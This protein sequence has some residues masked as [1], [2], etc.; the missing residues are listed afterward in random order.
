MISPTKTGASALQELGLS[1]KDF[2]DN[3]GNMKSMTDIFGLLHDKMQGMG[4]N[5]QTDIF[6]NL[7]GITGQQA[8]LI[9][10]DNAKQLGELNQK[11]ADSAKNDYVGKLAKKNSETGKVAL[12]IVKQSVNAISMTLL[13]APQSAISQIGDKLAK[14]AGTKEFG[15]AVK[16]VGKWVGNLTDKVADFF[17][18]LG[19]HSN[20]LKGITHLCGKKVKDIDPG[21]WDTFFGIIMGIGKAFGQVFTNGKKAEELQKNLNEYLSGIAMHVKALKTI[22]GL[23]AGIW[24]ADKVANFA[25]KINDVADA[26]GGLSKKLKNSGIQNAASEKVE[27]TGENISKGTLTKAENR[28]I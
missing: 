27:K 17:T 12:D 8:G 14:A 3:K 16:G 13:R 4:K 9:L 2:T 6:H 22:G 21:A 15:N 26:F 7:F 23:L 20:D 24:V 5:K 1:T 19:K 11:V 28:S 10:A 25:V 18:Y